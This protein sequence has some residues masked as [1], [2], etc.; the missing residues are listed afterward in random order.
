MEHRVFLDLQWRT[1]TDLHRGR[2]GPGGTLVLN[3]GADVARP[4][5]PWVVPWCDS[6]GEVRKKAWRVFDGTSSNSPL[7]AYIFQ[8]YQSSLVQWCR[9]EM[10]GQPG[11]SFGG[12]T[13]WDQPASWMNIMINIDAPSVQI[14]GSGWPPYG[15]INGF[16][17]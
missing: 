1:R 14:L 10:V 15:P 16:K 6:W 8:N 13:L 4:N 7:R 5:Y 9:A 12:S 2:G 17:N 3:P 11:L